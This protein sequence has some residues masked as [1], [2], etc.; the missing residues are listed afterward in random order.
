MYLNILW[1]FKI[2]I[3]ECT[4]AYQISYFQHFRS[5]DYLEWFSHLTFYLG[6][7]FSQSFHRFTPILWRYFRPRLWQWTAEMLIPHNFLFC[8]S[9]PLSRHRSVIYLP[10]FYTCMPCTLKTETQIDKTISI[11]FVIS[12]SDGSIVFMRGAASDT[13]GVIIKFWGRGLTE[14]Q[15]AMY[16]RSSATALWES[17]GVYLNLHIGQKWYLVKKF[18]IQHFW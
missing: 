15:M 9:S 18:S 10:T 1:N 3:L 11:Y 2:R 6:D 14:W 16:V 13:D 4:S 5:A 17:F 7:P 8:L 12:I